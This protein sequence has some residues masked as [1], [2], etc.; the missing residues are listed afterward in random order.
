MSQ[1]LYPDLP[2]QGSSRRSV[3][4]GTR[5]NARSSRHPMGRGLR[6]G[7]EFAK[8]AQGHFQ[9]HVAGTR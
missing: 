4:T 8:I 2:E 1:D 3:F 5:S 9:T 6:H 7:G